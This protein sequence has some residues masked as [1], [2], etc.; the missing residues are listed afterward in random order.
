MSKFI[1]KIILLFFYLILHTQ[2]PSTCIAEEKPKINL[3]VIPDSG[4]NDTKFFLQVTVSG[5]NVSDFKMPIMRENENFSVAIHS[6]SVQ[7]QQINGVSSQQKTFIFSLTPKSYLKSGEYA[8][9]NGLVEYKGE[10]FRLP[11]KKV[12]IESSKAFVGSALKTPSKD[13]FNFV[14]IVSNEKPYVGEQIS[15]R[16]E[17]I[18]PSN[19]LKAELDDFQV[20][21]IWRER[22]G[23]DE[24]KQ[25][26]AFNLTIHSFSESWFPIQSGTIAVPERRLN[27]ALQQLTRV[28]SNLG[29]SNQLLNNLL[30]LI[31]QFSTEE[32]TV[33]APAISVEVR[34]LP[35]PTTPLTGHIP[36][37]E[38]DITSSIDKEESKVGEPITLTI[39]VSGDANLKPLEI[40]KALT[41]MKDSELKRYDEK[42]ILKKVVNNPEVFFY[43]TFSITL[44]PLTNGNIKIPQFQFNWFDPKEEK[45]KSEITIEKFVSVVGDPIDLPKKEK[46]KVSP[47]NIQ[48]LRQI[49]AWSP[50][51]VESLYP[52]IIFFL[53]LLLPLI[54][55]IRTIIF[56]FIRDRNNSSKYKLRKLITRFKE[57]N[58]LNIINSLEFLKQAS[59]YLLK[60]DVNALT[61]TEI[62]YKILAIN[63]KLDSVTDIL[64]ELEINLYSPNPL[65]SENQQANALKFLEEL[66]AII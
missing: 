2:F 22:F 24:K 33:T 55:W 46:P 37:G 7:E 16:V 63:P 53:N 4:T 56:K 27:V 40:G 17:I 41:P 38:L 9:P 10:K 11:T 57:S 52:L 32:K 3:T 62:A 45:Y 15:Y 23:Q 50:F 64:N 18:A 58:D 51:K 47:L 59:S 19:M 34:P 21:G 43:K 61:G 35:Y 20:E 54:I 31:S 8:T 14:Q 39:Q 13:G 66:Y 6:N 36:V 44:I 42:P 65:T 1:L 26:Q 12:I 49:Y 30:P 29:L 60:E 5:E 48:K 28:P 25:R